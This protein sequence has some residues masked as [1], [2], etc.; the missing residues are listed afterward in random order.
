MSA[1]NPRKVSVLYPCPPSLTQSGK[2]SSTSWAIMPICFPGSSL[3][4]SG[5]LYSK[6]TL[7]NCISR[8]SEPSRSLIF[9]Y[10]WRLFCRELL[11]VVR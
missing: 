11:V 4:D 10:C 1:S 8:S 5:F 9:R 6:L 2:T 7:R 3:I